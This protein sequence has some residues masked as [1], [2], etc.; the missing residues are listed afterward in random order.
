MPMGKVSQ[1]RLAEAQQNA[2]RAFGMKGEKDPAV[3]RAKAVAKHDLLWS[4]DLFDRFKTDLEYKGRSADYIGRVLDYLR[5]TNR[6]VYFKPLHKFPIGELSRAMVA[7][8]LSRVAKENG[9]LAMTR[10]RSALS[11]FLNWMIAEGYEVAN[12]VQGTKKYESAVR[13]RVLMPEELRAIWLKAG[14]DQHGKIIRLIMLTALRRT[15]AGSLRKDEVKLA[16]SSV[17]TED[18]LIALPGQRGKRA[19]KGGSKHDD[20]FLLPLSTQAIK[21]L[22]SV[23]KREDSDYVFGEGE[24]GFSGW[25]RAK[26]ALDER[27]GDAI[28][29]PWGLHDFRR[30]F[31]TLG[32][33]VCKIP[34][35]HTDYCLNHKPASKAGVRKH[36]NFAKYLDEKRSAM[37]IWGDYIESLTKPQIKAV[38]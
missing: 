34:D 37:Q 27:I 33:D 7:K 29:E 30:S 14:D 17:K 9:P 21:L 10:A 28:T 35:A 19:R 3:E 25:S 15:Q 2:R 5:G 6:H 22:L 13:D 8:E 31:E 12:V 38:A 1:I 36:Y 32:H 20:K 26:A 18:R 23:D 11:K 24:G 16:A 4:D